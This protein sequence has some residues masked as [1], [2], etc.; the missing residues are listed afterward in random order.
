MRSR[1]LLEALVIT[2][3]AKFNSQNSPHKFIDISGERFKRWRLGRVQGMPW[4][5]S[6]SSRHHIVSELSVKNASSTHRHNNTT[7]QHFHF[8]QRTHH[9]CRTLPLDLESSVQVTLFCWPTLRY[10]SECL[11]CTI[12][13]RGT[14]NDSLVVNHGGRVLHNLFQ[15]CHTNMLD[16][17]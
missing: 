15:L 10:Q 16:A 12:F 7:P 4:G 9:C 8:G 14:D 6:V 2:T 3:H 11:D 17:C 1:A 13:W 5:G